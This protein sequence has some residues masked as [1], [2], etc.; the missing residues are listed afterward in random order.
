LNIGL[1]KEMTRAKHVLSKT[2]GTQSTPSSEKQKNNFS[3]RPW[4]LGARK[5]LEALLSNISNG[6]I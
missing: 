4:R 6:R 5:F 1:Q 2:E 3:L